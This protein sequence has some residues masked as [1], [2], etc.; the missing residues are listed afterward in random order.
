MTDEIGYVYVLTNEWSP[1][2]TKLGATTDIDSRFSSLSS[3]LPGRSTL[4]WSTKTKNC[5]EAEGQV[6]DILRKFS[7]RSS[8][9][10]F[11]C[12]P[13]LVIEQF[14]I[15]LEKFE[16]VGILES[17]GIS[18]KA[19]IDN[20]EDLGKYCRSWRKK[21][22]I[23]Q[24]TLAD[25]AGVGLRFVV[26]FEAGKPTCQFDMCIAVAKILGVDLIAI[27]RGQS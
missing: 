20:L 8:K 9:D 18:D 25:M 24:C 19:K 13:R 3:V 22:G 10:W 12:P 17:L 23:T 15:C 6:R 16:S 21:S 7:I 27:K 26:E 5:F 1:G 14:Q 2:L 4:E 11:S